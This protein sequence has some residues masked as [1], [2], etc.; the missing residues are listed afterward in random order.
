MKSFGK[1]LRKEDN[2]MYDIRC[3]VC[4][5]SVEAKA[6]HFTNCPVCHNPLIIENEEDD[7]AEEIENN[8]LTKMKME[9]E[10]NGND[11]VW[12]FIEEIVN[13][14]KRAEFRNLFFN[15]GGHIYPNEEMKI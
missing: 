3:N 5:F 12:Q 8:Q 7:V 10:R 4:G 1:N 9:I 11:K 2:I 14:H 13:P 15:A 6:I